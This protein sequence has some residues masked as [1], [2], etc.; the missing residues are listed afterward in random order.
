MT[1]VRGRR[2]AAVSFLLAA[3]I[4]GCPGCWDRVEL[5]D[6]GWV[7]TI[8]FDI[9]SQ[10]MLV[11]SFQIAIPHRTESGAGA[12]TQEATYLSLS[13]AA[14]TG[15]E[16]IDLASVTLG[17][18]LSLQHAQLVVFGEEC[19]RTDV[20][21]LAG[22]MDRFRGTRGT[23][24][25][26]VC[27]G[28]AADLIKVTMS[29]LETNP[30]KFILGLMQQ[31]SITG[32]FKAVQLEDFWQRLV[33]ED[34]QP[35][36]PLIAINH[37]VMGSSPEGGGPGG[38]AGSSG[39]SG[40]S[41]A[42]T[43]A[44]P[45][46]GTQCPSS[47]NPGGATTDLE[48]GQTP[49]L[50]GGP[51]EMLGSAVFKGGTMIGTITGD[52]TRA[53]LILTGDFERGAFSIPDPQFPDDPAAAWSVDLRNSREKVRVRRDG[54]SVT[55]DIK[56]E[57]DVEYLATKTLTDYT[58]PRN[59]PIAERAIADYVKQLVDRTIARS[60]R[61]FGADFIGFGLAVRKTFLTYPDWD[62]FLWQLKYPQA[63]ITTQVTVNLVRYGE[64]LGPLIVPPS[65]E[66][67]E[68]RGEGY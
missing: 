31:H 33:S 9:D 29:P 39:G 15:L 17:R 27:P 56:V 46:V 65:E 4:V 22:T 2:A 52:E 42:Q 28:R 25:V 3:I 36:C 40:G 30:S 62:A 6:L 50:G 45:P 60:Q 53:V 12:S 44:T 43:R 13:I 21:P 14:P 63:R 5:E 1:G 51:V 8:G 58:D 57:M 23:T 48:A 67:R 7:Q 18:K 47:P 61:E 34:T 55:L 16:A 26:A 20:R 41:D 11:T 66:F 37:Q 35:I 19:A 64:S 54:D 59:S 68:R 24:F 38:G 49:R 10:G 32:L